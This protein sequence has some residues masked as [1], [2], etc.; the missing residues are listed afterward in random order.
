MSMIP[1]CVTCDAP[2]DPYGRGGVDC[3]EC[4]ERNRMAK[5]Q[6]KPTEPSGGRDIT[7]RYRCGARYLWLLDGARWVA[8]EPA[9]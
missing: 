3:D 1:R 9:R 6:H 2:V 8:P 7:C 4:K 5:C